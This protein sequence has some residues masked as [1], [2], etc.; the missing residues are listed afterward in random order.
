MAN[1]Y[2]KSNSSSKKKEEKKMEDYEN[3]KKSLNKGAR[4]LAIVMIATMVLFTIAGACIF[5]F[6]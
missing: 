1:K 3:S 5:M 6:D 2:S 4:I